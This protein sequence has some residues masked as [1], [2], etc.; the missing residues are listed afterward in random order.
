M[1]G[2]RLEDGGAV[3]VFL[4]LV[5]PGDGRLAPVSTL[6][7]EKDGGVSNTRRSVSLCSEHVFN[8]CRDV[9]ERQ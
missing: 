8:T 6:V 4:F 5:E 1:E 2:V 3:L 9:L 7:G